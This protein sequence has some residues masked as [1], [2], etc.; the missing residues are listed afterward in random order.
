VA[1][2]VYRPAIGLAKTGFRALDLDFLVTGSEHI[3]HVGGAVMSANHVS[4]LDFIFVGKAADA[5]GRYVRFMA[6]DVVF[7]HPVVGPF[8]RGMKHIPVDREA[9]ADAYRH[10]VASLRAGELVGVFPEGTTS[11]SYTIKE[12]KTGAV[13]MAAEADVPV[14]PVI[15][16]GG[17]RIWT[18]GKP[19]D[20]RTRG[21]VISIRVG[22]PLWFTRDDDPRE[23][24][25]RMAQRLSELLDETVRA[26]PQGPDGPDDT[27][28][29][30]PEYGGTAL[31][32]EQ[33]HEIEE[34]ERQAR[35][36]R[37]AEE[38]QRAAAE[39]ATSAQRRRPWQRRRQTRQR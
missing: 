3:P 11:R 33:A 15:T 16:W 27:W 1:E 24:T 20:F 30:P 2:Y 31:T 19:R 9:G 25:Q 5:I 37:K 12:C 38:R 35:L 26:H 36:R 28:W 10:A 23:A 34:A 6:K 29:L 4:Y 39:A 8:M 17:Q 22:E 18:K 32:R 13:R 21:R 7:R 14:V